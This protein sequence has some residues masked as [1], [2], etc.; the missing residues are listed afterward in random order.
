MPRPR[1]KVLR[2]QLPKGWS[3][4]RELEAMKGKHVTIF[5]A[6]LNIAVRGRLVDADQF[7]IAIANSLGA[8]EIVFKH[9]MRSIKV[10]E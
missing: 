6:H 1:S 7:T 4:Q 5:L 3:H 10:D 2:D 9:A 8:T